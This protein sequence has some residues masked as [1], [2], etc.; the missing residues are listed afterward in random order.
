MRQERVVQQVLYLIWAVGMRTMR[1]W[2]PKL[3]MT[4]INSRTG[5]IA[6]G[7]VVDAVGAIFSLALNHMKWLSAPSS[8]SK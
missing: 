2:S 3:L 5:A 4:P 8:P 1:T 6:V 7:Y